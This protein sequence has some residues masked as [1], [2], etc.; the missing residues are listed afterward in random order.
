MLPKPLNKFNSTQY[1]NTSQ[2]NTMYLFGTFIKINVTF[3]KTL[4]LYTF[5]S[6]AV[7]FINYR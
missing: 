5:A 6:K 3:A 7:Y 4:S 2:Y 1:P